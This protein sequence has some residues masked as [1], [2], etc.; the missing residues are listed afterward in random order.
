[1]GG[2][3]A[4]AVVVEGAVAAARELGVEIVLVGRGEEVKA[5]LA[6]HNTTSLSLPIVHAEEVVSMDEHASAALRQKQRSSIAVGINLVREGLASA[7]VSAGNSGA[8]MAGALFGLGRIEGIERPAIGTV[9]PT[10]TGKCFVLDIGANADCK[11]EYLVQFAI[12]GSAYMERVFGVANPRVG[13]LSNG[14]EESK[15]NSLVQSAYP[16]LKELPVNFIGNVEG[17]DIPLGMADVVVC[18]GFC[19]NVVIKLSEGVG[20]A[21]FEI[22]KAELT[23][24]FVSKLAAL[25]LKPAFRRAKKRLDYAEYGGAPLLGVNGVVIIAHGR[26]NAVAIKNAVRVARQAVDQRLVEAIASG[27]GSATRASGSR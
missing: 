23:A 27:V 14:E 18:D 11:T 1:M 2:D 26:S 5:E 16:L 25:V 8:V 10:T 4:P 6:K 24:D 22:L 20:S 17:K 7:F 21:L 15:G 9:Y 19:G 13:L 12:M 3:H